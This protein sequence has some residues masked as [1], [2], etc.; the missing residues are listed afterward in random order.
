M[1]RSTQEHKQTLGA[2]G[3]AVLAVVRRQERAGAENAAMGVELLTGRGCYNFVEV[4]LEGQ[5]SWELG[6]RSWEE[7]R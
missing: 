2:D 5:G 3:L 1:G 6:A 7:C 4:G